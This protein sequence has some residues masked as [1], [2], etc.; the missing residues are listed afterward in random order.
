VVSSG[1]GSRV[2]A[3]AVDGIAGYAHNCG[4]GDDGDGVRMGSGWQW[5]GSGWMM[6]VVRMSGW[7][8]LQQLQ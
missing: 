4:D 8:W 6:D 1:W 7:D 2:H 3:H 5:M